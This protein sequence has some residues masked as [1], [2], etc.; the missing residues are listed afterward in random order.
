MYRHGWEAGCLVDNNQR[1]TIYDIN[2]FFGDSGS[3]IFDSQG[4]VVGV[5][6]IEHSQ[7]YEDAYMKV[8]GGLPIVFTPKQWL[9]ARDG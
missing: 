6:S 5:I 1:W 8:M 7:V 4:R 9:E 3:G 2:G